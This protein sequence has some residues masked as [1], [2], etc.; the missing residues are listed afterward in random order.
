[1]D[2]LWLRYFTILCVGLSGCTLSPLTP[3]SPHP[4]TSVTH[5]SP[6]ASHA[7]PKVTFAHDT[8][9][10]THASPPAV[11]PGT[12]PAVSIAAAWPMFHRDAQ[13]TGVANGIGN[14][15]P[16]TGPKVRWT[17]Q[18]TAPPSEADFYK[19][20]WYAS[21]PLGDL[22]GDGTLEV[23]VTTPD[24]SGEPDRVIALKDVPGQS[25][26]AQV[27]WTFTSPEP[28]GN[29]GFDQYSAALADAN[30]D[31]LLDVFFSAKSGTVR[32]LSGLTGQVIWEYDTNH[33]IEAGPMVADL[34][35]DGSQEVIVTTDCQP[36]PECITQGIQ[37]GALYVFAAAPGTSDPLLWSLDLL[38]KSDS[39]EAAIVDLDADDGQNIKA[40]VFGAWD[41]KLHVVWRNL[42]GEVVQNEVDVRSFESGGSG[43]GG[44][45]N[46]AIR[47]TLLLYDF[48]EGWTAVF[49]WMPDWN[50]GTEA[51][52]SAVRLN[53][54]MNARHVSFTPLWT[55]NRDDW[56]SS[57]SLLP[58]QAGAPLVVTGYGIGTTSGTG[59]Y[60]ACDPPLGGIIAINP[61]NGEIAWENVFVN[62]GNVRGSSAV[63]DI[64]GDGQLEVLLTVGCYGEIHAYDGT[65]GREEWSFQLGPRTI[66][67]P[68][69]GDLDGDG[70]LEIVVPSYDG[71]VWVLG[72]G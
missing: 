15:N 17:Y 20:R 28:P 56:K 66:G 26:S 51:R 72:G 14:I 60:G 45:P 19:Y 44:L 8:P 65:S 33:F 64:D 47:S 59:N 53:A 57:V 34:D 25:P 52:I 30:G 12:P 18:V 7:T 39:A 69:I 36:G 55:I 67:T 21:F 68:S 32:A 9:V 31:G 11:F 71:K 4:V 63:A 10:V 40:L 61:M 24:N 5:A 16:D 46:A 38:K 22:D 62:E 1:M 35:G 37:G 29:W 58:V 27:L 41:G 42:D 70:F 2:K 54:D 3:S 6:T 23:V 13:H 43:H 48:G 50:I 49:G